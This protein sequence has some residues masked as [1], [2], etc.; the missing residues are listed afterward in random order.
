MPAIHDI[1]GTIGVFLILSTYFLLQLGK[2]DPT[3]FNY[4]FLNLCGALAVLYSLSVE[5]NFAAAMVEIFW[6]IISLYG[7]IKYFIRKAS[8]SSVFHL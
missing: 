4:S 2:L 7:I 5:W 3:N 1:I 6:G 8:Q